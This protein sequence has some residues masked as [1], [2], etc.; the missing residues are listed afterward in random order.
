MP[1]LVKDY[2]VTYTPSASVLV[3]LEKTRKTHSQKETPSQAPLLAFGHLFALTD[4]LWRLVYA[5]RSHREGREFLNL[6]DG[7]LAAGYKFHQTAVR[8]DPKLQGWVLRRD[9]WDYRL[10]AASFVERESPRG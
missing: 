2:T 6:A 8:S 5:M 9:Y 1:Y 3:T 4:K 7:Y 10:P